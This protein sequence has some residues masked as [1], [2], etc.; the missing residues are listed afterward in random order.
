MRVLLD[1]HA[2]LWWWDDRP[3]LSERVRS[4]ILDPSTE[5][6]V[7]AASGWEIATK[8]R[9]GRPGFGADAFHRHR[10]MIEADGF[11]FLS[12]S[13][14]HGLRAGSYDH[15]HD[16]PFDRMLAAQ[17]EIENVVLLSAD[18]AMQQ[19]PCETLW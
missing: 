17:S 11:R 5:V 8:F 6:L 13:V 16:D 7:S 10:E 9:L 19:F 4:L 1:T 3:K 15:D 18:R 12:I 2:L 14:E